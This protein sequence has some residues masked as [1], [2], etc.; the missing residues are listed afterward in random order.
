MHAGDTQPLKPHEV[1]SHLQTHYR[2][3]FRKRVREGAPL[4]SS[5]SGPILPS[6]NGEVRDLG[7]H[8]RLEGYEELGLRALTGLMVLQSRRCCLTDADSKS[9]PSY[10]SSISRIKF[11]PAEHLGIA[12]AT[13]K[14]TSS[15]LQCS[16]KV[17]SGERVNENQDDKFACGTQVLRIVGAPG[18]GKSTVLANLWS[19][20]FEH[21]VDLAG[22]LCKRYNVE[23]DY[24]PLVQIQE[25]IQRSL[26]PGSFLSF[27]FT[28]EGTVEWTLNW[29]FANEPCCPILEW[30]SLCVKLHA[31]AQ[32]AALRT[33]QVCRGPCQRRL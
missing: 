6:S 31:G 20:V 4:A 1:L 12:D 14:M 3:G 25:R 13:A 15:L 22:E 32:A 10:C 33:L 18:T 27:T 21:I 5:R 11:H 30:R 29:V 8:L 28:N 7:S 2:V 16:M 24:P 19:Y 17:E 9:R 23:R 26:D